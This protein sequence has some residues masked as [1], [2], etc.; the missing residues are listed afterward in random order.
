[1]YRFTAPVPTDDNAT[2]VIT[3]H[4][5]DTA[6]N[7]AENTPATFR[8]VPRADAR[9]PVARQRPR[10]RRH[11]DRRAGDQLHLPTVEADGCPVAARRP[12][13]SIDLDQPERDQRGDAAPRSGAGHRERGEWRRADRPELPFQFIGAPILRMGHP[14]TGPVT[15]RNADRDRGQQLPKSRDQVLS[16]AGGAPSLCPYYMS[17]IR[18]E[19]VVRRRASR[20]GPCR[21]SRPTT[22]SAPGARCPIRSSTTATANDPPDGGVDPVSCA[23]GAVKLRTKLTLLALAVSALPVAIAGYSSLRIGQGALRGALEQNELT[24]RQAGRGLRVQPRRQHAVDAA[25]GRPHPGPDALGA[26]RAAVGAGAEPGAVA[27][28]SPE[29]RL[30]RGRDVRRARRADWQAGVAGGSETLRVAEEPRADAPHRRRG[31]RA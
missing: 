28:L 7:Q 22:R 2:V 6:G 25:R 3:P 17:P 21:S 16:L 11:G 19:G 13:D 31:R 14:L 26:E 1:M 5:T 12:S 4:A 23:G 20:P 24:R 18:I 29:R 8:L 15:R 9:Q 30:L 10:Q 27:R